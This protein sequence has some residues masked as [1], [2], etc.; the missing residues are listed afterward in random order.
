MALQG[1]LKP[2]KAFE[3]HAGGESV[4]GEHVEGSGVAARGAGVAGVVLSVA[5]N[6][7][8]YKALYKAP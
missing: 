2:Y 8:P 5:R 1:L 3:R 4:S 7:G 6:T